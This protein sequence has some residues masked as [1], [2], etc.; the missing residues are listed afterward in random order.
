MLTIFVL[1]LIIFLS[2]KDAKHKKA[3]L[4]PT[5]FFTYNE[6]SYKK[7]LLFNCEYCD[8][9]ISSV[10]SSCRFCGGTFYDNKQYQENRKKVNMQFVSFLKEQE[11]LIEQEIVYI[12]ETLS[13]LRKNWVMKNEFYNF[14]LGDKLTYVPR[15]SFDFCCEYCGTQLH[16]NSNDN[17]VCMNCGAPYT[18]NSSLLVFEQEEQLRKAHYNEYQKL[19]SFEYNQNINNSIK[20]HNIG[21]NAS[22]IAVIILVVVLLL[23][24]GLFMLL[25]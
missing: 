11:Q 1:L 5:Q 22:L 24:F 4:K 18:D 10:D 6:L 15:Y 7:H 16:G 3:S 20:D 21:S 17:N 19:K 25:H 12:E 23:E 9:L 8:G 14:D 13:A 2:I